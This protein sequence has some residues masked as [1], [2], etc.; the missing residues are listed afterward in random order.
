MSE[1]RDA[2]LCQLRLNC[3]HREASSTGGVVSDLGA[4]PATGRAFIHVAGAVAP[5]HVHPRDGDGDRARG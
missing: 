2:R 1:R 3:S 5:P 4:S